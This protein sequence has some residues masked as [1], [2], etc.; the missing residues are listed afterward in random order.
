MND[1]GT[2]GA[3]KSKGT[4]YCDYKFPGT[5]GV[6]V[7]CD[8]TVQN[9]RIHLQRRKIPLP[10]DFS[11]GSWKSLPA[12]KLHFHTI[13]AQNVRIRYHLTIL[14]PNHAGSAT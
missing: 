8:G 10:V 5:Q 12:P 11:D 13:A 4:A 3:D 1:T 2:H 14:A 9:C 6:G 7:A